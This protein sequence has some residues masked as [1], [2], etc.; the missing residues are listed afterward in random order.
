MIIDMS[1][2]AIE[3]RLREASRLIQE[4]RVDRASSGGSA[5]LTDEDVG[6][7]PESLSEPG[8]HGD[9]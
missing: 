1:G 7:D 8:D 6:G 2:Q 9:G 3:A 4:W 5:V